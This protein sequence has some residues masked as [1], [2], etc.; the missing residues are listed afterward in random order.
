MHLFRENNPKRTYDGP[1][2]RNYRQYRTRLREDFN[3]RCGYSDVSEHFLF[4][5]SL[6]HID[7][8]RPKAQ[9][10]FPHLETEYTN[11]VYCSC[12]VNRCK[13]DDWHGDDK[14]SFVE[15]KG[16]LDPCE[17]DYNEHFHR[18]DKGEILPNEESPVAKYM[19]KRLKLYL[20]RYGIFWTLE[21]IDRKLSEIELKIDNVQVSVSNKRD[22]E[23]LKDIHYKL[24]S[25]FRNHLRLLHISVYGD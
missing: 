15:D 3:R 13:K 5:T 14:I 2:K 19:Y 4:D 10:K 23:V 8:F 24:S 16:Y 1:R 25:D 17:V 20:K 21:R 6:F 12:Y 11:L 18:N 7:H 22:I 9:S